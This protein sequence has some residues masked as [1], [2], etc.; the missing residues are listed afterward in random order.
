MRLRPTLVLALTLF[1]RPSSIP[2]SYPDIMASEKRP[3][4]REDFRIAI[5]CAMPLEYDAV[6]LIFDTFFDEEG[7]PYGKAPGDTNQYT[8]GRIGR[9]D[10]VLV[11]LSDVGKAPAA[12]AAASV[13][14]SY[15]RLELALLVGVCGGV[16]YVGTDEVLLGDVVISKMVVQYDFGRQYSHRFK[17]K[18]TIEDCLGRPNKT[19]RGLIALFETEMGRARLHKKA[20]ERLQDLQAAAEG[21]RADYCYP[22]PNKDKLFKPTYLHRHR[23]ACNEC[24]ERPCDDAA[25]A[26]CEELC[27]EAEYLVS[28]KRL[29]KKQQV[30]LELA[31][32]PTIFV[33]RIGSGDSVMRSSQRRDELAKEQ[34][35]VA[36]EMEG[37]GVWDEVPCIVIKGISDY[38]DSHKDTLKLWHNF[39]AA[40]AAATTRAVLE[41]YSPADHG[42]P[43]EA[44]LYQVAQHGDL[45]GQQPS[46]L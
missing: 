38:A 16:P 24:G 22:G 40:T 33:G 1:D 11:L 27:C 10:V 30:A 6:S 28:R 18:D 2:I 9:H 5:I 35:L 21:R 44:V 3:A 46:E 20:A 26:S 37:A 42:G 4:R 19:I 32:A 23:K 43:A 15:T 39:A 17:I 29:D 8:T 14:S 31:Q 7:D 12:G 36:F 45:P 34:Q 25:S 41:R 13:R